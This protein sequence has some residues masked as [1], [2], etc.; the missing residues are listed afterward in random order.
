MRHKHISSFSQEEFALAKK[1]ASLG[2]RERKKFQEYSF[3][4]ML[5]IK[6]NFIQTLKTDHSAQ[7]LLFTNIIILFLAIF[8]NWSFSI[9][10]ATYF[11]QSLVIGF[12]HF[13]RILSF[14]DAQH[15][16][17]TIISA[18]FFLVHYGIFHLVYFIFLKTLFVKDFFNLAIITP[19]LLLFFNHLF[20]FFYNK[21]GD[22]QKKQSIT[23]IMFEPY[24]RILPM[25]FIIIFGG[26]L[27]FFFF[28]QHNQSLFANQ[29]LLIIFLLLK[30]S[31]D[32]IQHTKQHELRKF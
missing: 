12:F 32:L 9:L 23:N 21:S 2:P 30:I 26:F 10:I 15:R 11:I 16:G 27:S 17:N 8:Q 4:S 13:F 5:N 19:S 20:S 6:I 14:R 18:F 28:T 3:S 7:L 24:P 29:I 25:H 31:M 1:I 22:Q